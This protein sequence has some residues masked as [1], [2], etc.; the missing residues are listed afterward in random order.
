MTAVSGPVGQTSLAQHVIVAQSYDMQCNRSSASNAVGL[1]QAA[2][3]RECLMS[4]AF[5]WDVLLSQ[6]SF[7]S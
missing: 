1:A 2:S 5:S 6:A 7:D 4:C 3:A